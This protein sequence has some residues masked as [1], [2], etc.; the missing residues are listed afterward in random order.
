[1]IIK[2][3]NNMPFSKAEL[4]LHPVRLRI[5]LAISGRQ[6]TA[7]DLAGALPDVAQ[8]TLYRHINALA[9][10]EILTVVDERPVRGTVEKTYALPE[11]HSHRLTA[12]DLAGL[13]PEDHMHY[14]TVF[15]AALLSDFAAYLQREQIDPVADGVGYQS[16]PLYLSDGELQNLAAGIN[17]LV[18]PL[19]SNGP[20]EGRTRRTFSTVM[21]PTESDG[22]GGE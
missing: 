9:E 1:L 14:F 17:A 4:I 18:I 10:G 19:L 8:A 6:M 16:V 15:V 13:G 5:I 22:S 7:Q 12:E 21:I 2:S 11:G 20:G 3:E